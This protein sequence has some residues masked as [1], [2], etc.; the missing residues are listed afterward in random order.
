MKNSENKLGKWTPKKDTDGIW[1][2]PGPD[3]YT[4]G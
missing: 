4:L 2:A 1:I 3:K